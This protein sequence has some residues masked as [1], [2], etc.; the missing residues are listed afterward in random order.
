M[1]F[2]NKSEW[3]HFRDQVI[4]LDNYTCKNC[5]RNASEV[6]LQ[7][8]H[9]Q[10]IKGRMPWEYPLQDCE[11][12]CKGCHSSKHGITKPQVGWEFVGEED[13][14]DLIGTCEN[15]GASIRHSFLI[16]H[17][18]WSAIEVGTFCCDKLTDTN[19]ASNLIESQT[20][21]KTRKQRFLKSKRWKSNSIEHTI[22]LGAFDVAI[23]E[24]ESNFFIKI[25]NIESKTKYE[26]LDIAKSK[27]FDVIESGA[28]I[29]YLKKHNV[30]MPESIKRK[31]K[32]S[33]I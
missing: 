14:G 19:I 32:N 22:M 10:Y 30:P 8:H 33:S 13:L 28:F 23:I 3:K 24:K 4:E 27:V 15:C 29:E 31:K 7:V 18:N 5:G 11:T 1:S 6:V 20:S 9:K 12:L 26:T 2:Y 25:H 16:Q 17:E 21:Y